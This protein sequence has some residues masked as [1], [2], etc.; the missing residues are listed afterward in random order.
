MGKRFDS[1][2]ARARAGD[3]SA[4]TD[5]GV[6]YRYGVGVSPSLPR[7]LQWYRRAA[8]LGEPHAHGNLSL[9]YLYGDGVPKSARR[10]LVHARAAARL[11]HIRSAIR[12]ACAHLDGTG[13]SKNSKLGV[14]QLEALEAE[15]YG[16]ARRTLA[17]RLIDGDGVRKDVPRGLLLLR[18]GAGWGDEESWRDLATYYHSKEHGAAGY[19]TALRFYRR[20][21]RGGSVAAMLNLHDCYEEGH[22]GAV[23]KDDRRAVAWLRRA[24]KAPIDDDTRDSSWAQFLY[25]ER[26]IE[27]RGVRRDLRK[28]IRML[29]RATREE[30]GAA[31]LT[32]AELA[33]EGK[34]MKR[35][36]RSARN[37]MLKAK[38]LEQDTRKLERRMRTLA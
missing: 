26:L 15:G 3:A 23:Q 7:A 35:D 4:A 18:K 19:I 21:A 5:V 27:G 34:G 24:L 2:L 10:F 12:V 1:W 32:L 37:W 16:R 25:A 28:G 17:R 20:A 38:A 14:K 11:G 22:V 13:T 36:L 29:W 31:W 8:K 30:Q 33:F 6:A 9:C